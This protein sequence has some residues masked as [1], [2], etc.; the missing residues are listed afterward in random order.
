MSAESKELHDL[1]Q[2]E[3]A[4]ALSQCPVP[5]EVEQD[6]DEDACERCKGE[7]QIKLDLRETCRWPITI[8]DGNAYYTCPKCGGRGV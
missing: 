2:A 1:R 5:V 4:R 7:G 3:Y 6:V 8:I